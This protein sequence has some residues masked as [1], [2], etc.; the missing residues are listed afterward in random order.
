MADW[1]VSSV[2]YAAIPQWAATHAYTVGNFVRALATPAQQQVYVFRC[3]TAGTS[4]GSEPGWGPG[5]G[6]DNNT[7]GDGTAVWTNVTGHGAYGWSAAGG[8]LY[9]LSSFFSTRA[10]PGDR[11][12]LS[13][14]HSESLASP[15]SFYWGSVQAFGLVQIISVNRAGSTPPVAADLLPGAAI[16]LTAGN[17]T[18]EANVNTYYEGITFTLSGA[19]GQNFVFNQNA[20]K[21]TYLKNCALVMNANSGSHIY[22]GTPV[23]LILDGT[24]IQ[25]GN[26][27]QL[28]GQAGY[29]FEL[30][31]INKSSAIAGAI[32]P[33]ILLSGGTAGAQAGTVATFRGV[34][35]SAVTGTLFTV[36]SYGAQGKVLFDSCRIAS[37]V[38]RMSTPAA[39][40]S[41]ADEFELV[42]CY[43]GTNVL[44]ERYTSA[45]AIITDRSTTLSGGVQDDTGVYSLKLASSSR[46][47]FL[48]MPVDSFWFD[49]ENSVI[50]MSKTATVEILSSLLLNN[51][52]I[53]LLLE[54]LGTVGSPVASF[55]NSL[56]SSLAASTA[57]PLSTA[58]WVGP[59]NTTWNPND[60][61][62]LTLSSDLL[63][64]TSNAFAPGAA[65]RTVVG[66]GSGK[67][68]FEL[69]CS[70]WS[71][72]WAGLV[73]PSIAVSASTGA[74]AVNAGGLVYVNGSNISSVLPGISTATLCIAVD[75]T[76]SL[77]WFRVGPTGSWNA[78]SGTANNPAT[79]VGGYS[80]STLTGPLFPYF[81]SPSTTGQAVVIRTSFLGAVPSGFTAGWP[82]TPPSK[83]KFQVTF[84]PQVIGRVRGLVRLG[85][86]STTVWVNPQITIT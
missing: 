84:T 35:V 23:K 28:L 71:S 29:P 39:G 38:A 78:S 34:D 20:N 11:I 80:F 76:N 10:V 63:T 16:T 42:N 85:K 3:T 2:A 67:Y 32:A 77:I 49:V 81:A 30:V 69:D 8:N 52:D 40:S 60:V 1:Y 36:S 66:A 59:S 86:V 68:Y 41:S 26:V 51:N 33:T 75:L 57:L 13:S 24:S 5:A 54:Y 7:I 70:G 53:Q 19:G 43:D 44:N 64:A 37:G 65:V 4:G 55:G 62:S 22:S 56:A 74:V 83:Q 47:D 46:S 25:F 31:W 79:G 14:D 73:Q 82:G 9:S 61:V 18:I 48:A 58:T 72:A 6:G 12:F 17:L 50:G 27:S 15:S 45:G 21:V